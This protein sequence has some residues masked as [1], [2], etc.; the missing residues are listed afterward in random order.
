[1]KSLRLAFVLGFLASQVAAHEVD[2]YTLPSGT[3]F[4]D[5]G[6]YLTATVYDRIEH[7]VN[8]LNDG[9][10]QAGAAERERLASP[11]AL[12]DAVRAEFP[13]PLDYIAGLERQLH[14]PAFTAGYGGLIVAHRSDPCIYDG[15]SLLIEPRAFFLLWRS[16]LLRVNGVF[17]GTD[18]IGHFVHNGYNYYAAYRAELRAGAD[19]AAAERAAVRVGVDGNLF[20][21]ERGLLGSL[22]SSVISNA[23]LA[24]NY[25]GFL[26]YLNLTQDVHLHG[27]LQL[28]LVRF[29]REWHLASHVRRNSDFLCRFF[30]DHLD[31]LL[32]PNIYE[33]RMH[34]VVQDR[35]AA[36][37]ARISAWYAD[38]NGV[39]RSRDWFEA[40]RRELSTYYGADYGYISEAP[41]GFVIVANICFGTTTAHVVS[42]TDSSDPLH[43]TALMRAVRSGDAIRVRAA[44]AGT[45]VNVID[46]DGETALH[47]AA[48]SGNAQIAE[49]LVAAGARCDI[50]NRFGRTPLHLAAAHDA[51]DVLVALLRMP[52]PVNAAD[53]FGVTALHDA[54]ASGHIDC[55]ARLIAAGAAL[56]L[57]DCSGNTPLHLAARAGRQDV[58]E[59][60][61]AAGAQR[62]LANRLHRTPMMEAQTAGFAHLGP[63]F[64]AAP[65]KSLVRDAG[66]SITAGSRE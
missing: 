66:T 64:A 1:M 11:D 12:A 65:H 57:A 3:R 14:D 10:R 39:P 29:D 60:L 31:E 28:P 50:A 35:V 56:D 62:N 61:L 9:L 27:E 17:V 2:H 43:R 45:D 6:P 25:L 24:A 18:K 8:R 63:L 48:R 19:S 36:Q 34:D 53:T 58:V 44:L 30:S 51:T 20:L 16:S 41:A 21:S 55:V 49:S 13:G 42:P 54:A 15:A 26:F 37:C 40:Q 33:Q 59:R 46:L 32:N 38:A 5:L 7:A 23:D 52:L 4:A 22:T 47:H